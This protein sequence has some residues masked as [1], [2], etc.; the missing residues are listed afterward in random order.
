MT[1]CLNQFQKAVQGGFG[2]EDAFK[3]LRVPTEWDACLWDTVKRPETVKVPV[4]PIARWAASEGL[5]VAFPGKV[6]GIDMPWI[7]GYV[8][9]V[10][11]SNGADARKPPSPW[12]PVHLWCTA[13]PLVVVPGLSP[14]TALRD[15]TWVADYIAWCMLLC[16]TDYA[17]LATVQEDGV[18]DVL[19]VSADDQLMLSLRAAAVAF[20]KNTESEL[21][22]DDR[23]RG[24][25]RVLPEENR[26]ASPDTV[27]SRQMAR[28]ASISA[29]PL[30]EA[31]V[32][33][34][35]AACKTVATTSVD[36]A[37][38]PS[39]KESG[40]S[41]VIR[42]ERVDARLMRRDAV[43]RRASP[44]LVVIA[45]RDQAPA[46]IR[47]GVPSTAVL[48]IRTQSASGDSRAAVLQWPR[49]CPL[50][51]S[52]ALTGPYGCARRWAWCRHV[53]GS[54][55]A[56]MPSPQPDGGSSNTGNDSL[57]DDP[58]GWESRSSCSE[59]SDYDE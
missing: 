27:L 30:Q 37:C 18:V 53:S 52:L 7:V 20:Y 9:A 1:D 13:V 43:Q 32:V 10:I 21:G 50:E 57:V 40:P 15:R 29:P 34:P 59:E 39:H 46:G 49:K 47:S 5:E 16:S 24:T 55:C 35:S 28:S 48:P 22:S 58:D 3:T 56:C 45:Q 8:P 51:M 23:Q 19:L 6:T 42:I 44:H 26:A 4:G 31:P 11:A 33:P 54:P 41:R 25:E 38:L 12:L 14:S 36:E 2:L 17:A